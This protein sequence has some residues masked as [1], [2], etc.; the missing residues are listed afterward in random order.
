VQTLATAGQEPLT[1]DGYQGFTL[2]VL[3]IRGNPEP[4]HRLALNES[5]ETRSL[6]TLAHRYPRDFAFYVA[7]PVSS[8]H[9]LLRAPL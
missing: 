3:L 7:D 6:P 5:I 1:I 9:S 4:F 8:V 2:C